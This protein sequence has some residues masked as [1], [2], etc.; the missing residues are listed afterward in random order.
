V[1]VGSVS[2]DRARRPWWTSWSAGAGDPRE[3]A[4]AIQTVGEM[5]YDGFLL[6]TASVYD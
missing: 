2:R 3:L 6:A 4:T 1:T 5:G